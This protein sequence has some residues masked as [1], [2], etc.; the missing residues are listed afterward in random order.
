MEKL[1]NLRNRNGMLESHETGSWEAQKLFQ[2]TVKSLVKVIQKQM[3]FDLITT[4]TPEKI[5]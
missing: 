3:W 1:T 5:V 4:R 2:S